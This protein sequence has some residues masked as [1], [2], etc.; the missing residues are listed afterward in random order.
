MKKVIAALIFAATLA[1]A[2]SVTAS[3]G[4]PILCKCVP[5]IEGT[6]VCYPDC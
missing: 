1:G 6:L 5:D 4:E 3:A 2:V